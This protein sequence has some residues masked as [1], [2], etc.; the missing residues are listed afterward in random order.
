MGIE[1]RGESIKKSVVLELGSLF[2]SCFF[3]IKL[4]VKGG[5]WV[6]CLD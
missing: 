2:A 3:G 5:F 6:S 4:F 1:L